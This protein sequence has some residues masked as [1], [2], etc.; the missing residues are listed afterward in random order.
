LRTDD[1]AREYQPPG[2]PE[3]MDG[4]DPGEGEDAWADFRSAAEQETERP[5]Q[6]AMPGSG[7]PLLR[8]VGQVGASYLVAEGPDGLYMIDQHAAHERVL[9]ERF[10]AERSSQ[11][12]SQSLLDPI[13]VEMSA[14]DSRLLEEN[15]P[16]LNSLGFEVEPFGPGAFKVRAIPAL[17][18]GSDPAAALRVLIED[19]EED[20][21]PLQDEVEARVI[22]RV[23][24]RA[25]VKAG[26][27]L[28]QDEQKALLNDLEACQSPRTCPHGR[29]T[30]IHLSID[31]LE[32]QFG[33][34]GAR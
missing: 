15:L 19:F 4:E 25:A 8:L 13:T 27:S 14:G 11:I 2:Q 5:P 28:S 17:L 3:N 32:R 34:K 10:M 9:F 16:I 22:A 24:K 26:Q 20:E 29:P 1:L 18:L 7:V 30:M 12:P 21:T 31:L 23:C 33:R 6:R